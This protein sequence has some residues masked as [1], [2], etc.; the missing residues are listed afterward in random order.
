ML[1]RTVSIRSR[2]FCRAARCSE[3][4][5]FSLRKALHSFA[6]RAHAGRCAGSDAGIRAT[7]RLAK[8]WQRRSAVDVRH[9]LQAHRC[10][11]IEEAVGEHTDMQGPREAG[12]HRAQPCAICKHGRKRAQFRRCEV[13]RLRYARRCGTRELRSRL[14]L[15]EIGQQDRRAD[16]AGVRPRS[17][18]R[19][20]DRL[21]P[22]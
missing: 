1:S 15:I 19:K 22:A 5:R 13:Q 4:R 18:V 2:S 14:A 9:L 11:G 20:P 21:E 10:A 8:C 7:D 17:R 12:E 6:A 3:D 16:R